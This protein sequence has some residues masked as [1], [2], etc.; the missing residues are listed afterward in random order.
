MFLSAGLPRLSAHSPPETRE[1]RAVT[2]VREEL[3]LKVAILAE[4]WA[5][6][7]DWYVDVILNLIRLAG[8]YVS[9]EVCPLVTSL[10]LLTCHHVTRPTNLL[11]RH[12]PYRHSSHLITAALGLVQGH[13]D[14]HQHA[15]PGGH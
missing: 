15:A 1:S 5:T 4:R 9:E 2:Q 3:V 13:P 8:D 6:K 10:A 12:S 11:Y 14:S 7:F